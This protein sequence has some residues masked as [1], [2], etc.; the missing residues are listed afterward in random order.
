VTTYT[1]TGA[2][3]Y[4]RL[5]SSWRTAA[6]LRS[7]TVTDPAT[8]LLPTNLVQG[9]VAVSWLTADAN[10]RYSFTCDSPGVVVDFGAGAQVLYANEVPG[11]AIAAGGA[12]NT[13]IDTHLGG[14]ATNLIA[15][16]AGKLDSTVAS[17]TY[18]PLSA[19]QE[20]MTYNT[21]GTVN[22][23]TETASGAVTTYTYNTDG[24][25]ATEARLLG[26]VTTTRTFTYSAGN[27]VGIA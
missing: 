9:G 3:A 1:F 21:D 4:D 12:T 13:A 7:V 20:T 23:V 18:G 2:V 26:G 16:V 25:P 14:N 11:L 15:T 17:S 6:G 24:T 27:L 8:G 22:T 5:G 19:L 10:S